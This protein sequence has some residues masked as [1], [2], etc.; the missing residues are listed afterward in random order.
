MA[1]VKPR[2]L[3]RIE[4]VLDTDMYEGECDIKLDHLLSSLPESTIVNE[5]SVLDITARG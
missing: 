1:E 5:L 3:L 2:R 4:I